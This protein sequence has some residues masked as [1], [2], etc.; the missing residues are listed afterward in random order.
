[1]GLSG[2]D[3]LVVR[4]C[5]SVVDVSAMALVCVFGPPG[6]PSVTA[7]TPAVTVSVTVEPGVDGF[8]G[9]GTVLSDHVWVC[10]RCHAG[11]VCRL[12]RWCCR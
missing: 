5:D 1:M 6:C 8:C 11:C 9:G 10:P 7:A 12:L 4:H 2:V 3:D